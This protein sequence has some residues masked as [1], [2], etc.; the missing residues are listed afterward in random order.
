MKS[1]HTRLDP[2]KEEILRITE[3]F[4]PFKAMTDFHVAGYDRFRIWLKEVT[5]DENFGSRPKIRLDGDQ[6]LGDQLVAAFLRKVARFQAENEDLKKRIK[7]LEWQ[8]DH[9]REK[10][11]EQALAVLE[12]C[13]A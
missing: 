11:Q 12:V 13:Q 5:G 10:E 3:T 6:S 1:L 4:G 2:R 7:L 8:L 9:T